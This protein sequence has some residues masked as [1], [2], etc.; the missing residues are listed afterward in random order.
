MEMNPAISII[1][2][3][4][5]GKEF[6]ED[7]L[8]SIFK[9]N[10]SNFEVILVDNGSTDDSLILAEK[11]FAGDLRLKIV[12]NDKNLLFTGGN[13]RGIAE[14]S[15]EY[16]IV[17]NNDT[18][19]HPDWLKYVACTMQDETIGAAQPKIL[20]FDDPARIDYI[21]GGLDRYGY[22]EGIGRRMIDS[23]QFDSMSEEIFYAGGA[24]M[25]LRKKVLDEVGTFDTKFGAYW[26]DTD[27][28]WRV[29]LKKYRI[30]AIPK[31]VV[32]HRVS[33]TMKRFARREDISWH[34]RKNRI[35]GLIKNYCLLNLIKTLPVLLAI[36]FLIFIKEIFIDR[37]IKVALSSIFAIGWNI[38]ELPYILRQ[39][40]IVQNKIRL[41][42]DKEITEFMEKG[43]IAFK[44]LK[45][46]FSLSG[47]MPSAKL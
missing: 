7:C 12:K 11:K 3:N 15:G 42:P 23:G 19:V 40:K 10:Y 33:G 26:E 9:S 28:S 46:E 27:L 18:T 14:A 8:R 13:N 41:V 39:R 34:A 1:V 32:Y 6:L 5:N 2:L 17:L 43:F 47:K 37:N 16:V 29:R 44:F 25:I 36:Y 21:G 22:A 24:A 38:K 31:A 35:A 20:L 45:E 4:Y 30:V